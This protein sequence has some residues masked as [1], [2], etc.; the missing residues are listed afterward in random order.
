MDLQRLLSRLPTGNL[1]SHDRNRSI[2]HSN[3]SCNRSHFAIS[4]L[5]HIHT[6]SYHHCSTGRNIHFS[7]LN[8]ILVMENSCFNRR[9]YLCPLEWTHRYV[10]LVLQLIL[11]LSFLWLD[12]CSGGNNRFYVY[13]RRDG[14][15]CILAIR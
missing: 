10:L 13:F 11:N 6:H 1:P 5:Q 12:T 7:S 2:C 3:R 8:A 15:F 9:I 14:W 4:H